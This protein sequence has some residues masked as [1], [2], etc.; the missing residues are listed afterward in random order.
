MNDTTIF[1]LR[2][3]SLVTERDKVKGDT[4]PCDQLPVHLFKTGPQYS[5]NFL[6]FIFRGRQNTWDF[7]SR[8]RLFTFPDPQLSMTHDS[9]CHLFTE[10][11]KGDEGRI[12]PESTDSLWRKVPES[13]SLRS[14]F[15]VTDS[16]I[17]TLFRTG[18]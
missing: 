6:V 15:R 13:I 5:H 11:T 18:R 14:Y 2:F 17:Y 1:V 7:T 10:V 16:Y 8:P 4:F 3:W 12:S 9:V